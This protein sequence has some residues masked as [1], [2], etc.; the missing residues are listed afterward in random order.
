[1]MGNGIRS[2]TPA[3][4]R[5]PAEDATPE[6]SRPPASPLITAEGPEAVGTALA[7]Q[8]RPP[9][10]EGLRH[11]SRFAVALVSAAR[12]PADPLSAIRLSLDRISVA[13]RSDLFRTR[14]SDRTRTYLVARTSILLAASTDLA[15]EGL[16][17]AWVGAVTALE[18][19]A[20]MATV[21]VAVFLGPALAGE[22]GALAWDGRIGAATGDLAGRWAGI[23]GGTTLIGMRRGRRTTTTGTTLTA[24][25]T[26][27][28]PTIPML[29]MTTTRGQA[30]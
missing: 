21:G 10:G 17:A 26:I 16:A 9:A 12:T 22:V 23:L 29:R 13:P 8:G 14:D 19:S 2:A 20:D 30:T 4:P 27:R 1:M 28:R 7:R 25:T 6:T 3:V 15:T 18:G 5:V 24:C 11:Q